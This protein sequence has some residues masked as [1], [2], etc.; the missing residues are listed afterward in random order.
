MLV[1]LVLV[2]I[3]VITLDFQDSGTGVIASIRSGA[4]DAFAP[5]Q[6]AADSVLSPVGDFFG[7]FTRYRRVKAENGHLRAQVEAAKGDAA[8]GDDAERERRLL[9]ALQGLDFVGDLPAVSAR[10]VADSPSN[11]QLTVSIDRGTDDRVKV[12]MPVVT[13]GGLVGRVIEASHSRSTVLLLNDPSS[14]VGVRLASSGDLGVVTG[15]GARDPLK[16]DLVSFETKVT[17]GEA[18]ITSGL[19]GG[20]FP[21]GLPVGRVREANSRPGQLQQDVVVDTIVDLRRL[22]LVRV[23]L[24]TPDR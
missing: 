7:G 22:Q 4:R 3:T 9:L 2:S 15:A 16:V 21:P 10:L 6:S 8:R 12:G 23:L 11:F 18:L 13:D 5:V 19:Q 17:V 14:A 1:L 24:W 20:L